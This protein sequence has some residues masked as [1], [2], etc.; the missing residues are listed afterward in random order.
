MNGFV[1][2][3][4]FQI[5]YII[6]LRPQTV[7][8]VYENSDTAL[9]IYFVSLKSPTFSYLQEKNLSTPFLSEKQSTGRTFLIKKIE[10]RKGK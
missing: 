8:F 2:F 1:L 5:Q 4:K 7:F 10:N 6:D 3:F 9:Y